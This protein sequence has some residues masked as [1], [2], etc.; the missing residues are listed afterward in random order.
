MV[1]WAGLSALE[2]GKKTKGIRKFKEPLPV[3]PSVKRN[4]YVMY[5]I[6]LFANDHE[7][8]P[9]CPHQIADNFHYILHKKKGLIGVVHFRTSKRT[10]RGTFGTFKF[11]AAKTENK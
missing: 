11:C 10:V 4:P 1:L 5:H 6:A 7:R 2:R 9:M 8:A 3:N